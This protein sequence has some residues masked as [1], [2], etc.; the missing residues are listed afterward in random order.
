M[1]MTV[2][3]HGR[4]ALVSSQEPQVTFGAT[5]VSC[6][7]DTETTPPQVEKAHDGQAAAVTSVCAHV[8]SAQSCPTLCDPVDCS[9]P[10]SSVHGT[11]QARTM[12]WVAMPSSRGS[13]R[14]RD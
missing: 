1:M 6:L 10:G 3:K 14:P 9:P 2:S 5:P 8:C 12:G 11:L 7:T 4:A 13:S